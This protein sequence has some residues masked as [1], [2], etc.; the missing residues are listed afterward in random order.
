MMYQDT[1]RWHNVDKSQIT[2]GCDPAF[3]DGP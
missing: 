1:G 3:S 2:G